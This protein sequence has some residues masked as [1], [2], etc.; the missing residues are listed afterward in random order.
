MKRSEMLSI[1]SSLIYDNHTSW[2]DSG[3]SVDCGKVLEG[4]VKAGMLPPSTKLGQI[5]AI[6]NAWDDETCPS[7]KIPCGTDWCCTKDVK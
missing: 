1:L 7:C 4:L 2:G 5:N 6:D 3:Y